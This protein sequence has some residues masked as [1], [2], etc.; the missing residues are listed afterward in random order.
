MQS[1][2]S[3]VQSNGC[4]RCAT[5]A[6]LGFNI[7]MAFQPIVDLSHR[8]VLAHEALVRGTAGESAAS[9]L[10]QVNDANRYQFDQTC[11]VRAIELAAQLGLPGVSINFLPNAVYQP[12]R[13]IRTTLAAAD[14]C[15][16]PLDRIIFEITE[17]EKVE[18]PAH[19]RKIITHYKSWG[20]LTAIDDFGAGY[21]GLALLADFQP[22]IVKLDMGLIRNIEADR[23]RLAIVRGVL[24]V[25][26]DLGIKPLAEGVE[27]QAELDVLRGLGV[28]LFQGYFFAK[29][30]FESCADVPKEK[31]MA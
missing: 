10:A 15:G 13:C 25:C 29:P 27:T 4:N 28:D 20:F 22:D 26:R 8:V 19:I 31:L 5:E 23:G 2:T 14:A 16:Y 6:G 24:Q 9:I 18:D 12:E 1:P 3:L 30:A 7:S 17:G 11:R 21:A